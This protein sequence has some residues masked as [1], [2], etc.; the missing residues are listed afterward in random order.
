MSL[1]GKTVVVTG[2]LQGI[3]RAVLDRFVKEGAFVF[4]CCQ[5]SDE[6]F[7]AHMAELTGQYGDVVVPVYF[8]LLDQQSIRS[9]VKAI[10][11]AK[12][13]VNG[14]VNV[15]GCAMDALFPMVTLEQMHKVFEVNF[16]SQIIFTQYIVKLM[17]R[18]GG[19]SVVSISSVTALDG[20]KGQLVYGASKAAWISATKTMSI[21]LGPAG[22][23]VNAIAPGV[24]LTPMTKDLVETALKP[25]IEKTSLGRIGQVEEI[26]ATAE[27]LVS[28]ASSFVTG[29]IVRVD[30][31]LN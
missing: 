29:Q 5:R 14:L 10:M 20:N 15:A 26:A 6:A 13:S 30:G 17:M 4:A 22:I 23:R 25:K 24:I 11:A 19:G 21:E 7:S 28:D 8:D 9:A 3:G 2:V 18:A 1:T 31:G 27:F 16:F 12:R